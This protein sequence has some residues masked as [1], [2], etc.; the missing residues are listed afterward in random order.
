MYPSIKLLGRYVSRLRIS[1]AEDKV[2]AIRKIVFLDTLKALK[3]RIIFFNYYYKYVDYYA[4][5]V[6]LL[7]KLKT[8][9]SRK[10]LKGS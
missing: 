6:A 5:V 2:E 3:T 9:S 7:I 10:A 8:I 1:I 4:G